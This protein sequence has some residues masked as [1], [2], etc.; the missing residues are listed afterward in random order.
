MLI[1]FS[2]LDPHKKT[3]LTLKDWISSFSQFNQYENLLNEVKANLCCKFKDAD[4]AFAYITSF[5]PCVNVNLT[6]FKKA[7][8]DLLPKRLIGSVEL[9]HAYQSIA[10]EQHHFSLKDFKREFASSNFIGRQG[11]TKNRPQSAYLT[12]PR[13]LTTKFEVDPIDK[14]RRLLK[15]SNKKIESIFT[16]VS[17]NMEGIV[18]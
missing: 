12:Q 1:V 3:F 6:T 5:E 18:S 2:T 4:S 7:I 9:K 17:V 15:S 8:H 13:P 11:K 16:K 10:H 14:I